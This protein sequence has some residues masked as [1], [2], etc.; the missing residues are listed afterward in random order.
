[1]TLIPTVIEK[2]GKWERAY[3][4]YSRLLEDRIIFIWEEIRPHVVNVVVAQ[5]L[6]LEKQDPDKEIIIYINTP[7]WDVYSG[8][9]IYDAM[10][11]VKC[12]IRTVVVWLAASMGSLYLVGWTKWLRCALPN[13]RIMIH[14]PLG[15]T[16]GQATDIQIQAEEMLKTKKILTQIIADWTGQK[17][18][19]VAQDMERD[20]RLNAEEAL[21]YGI[22]DQIIKPKDKT[23][24]KKKK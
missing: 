9:A 18:E 5:I 12:P 1:M 6:F 4:I 20:H 17:Y 23:I 10:Q 2:T 3:D 11:Y 13:S 16:R 24:A 21:K 15:W 14:Q 19:K 22:I 7:G 8:M